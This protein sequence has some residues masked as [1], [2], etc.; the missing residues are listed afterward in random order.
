[1]VERM[2]K[3]AERGEADM[4]VLVQRARVDSGS[5]G[6]LYDIYYGRIFNYCRHRLYNS[7]VAEDI[8]SKVFLA[9]AS[10]IKAFK[11]RT[12]QEFGSWIYTI[13]SNKA[14]DYLRKT[15][16]RNRILL[17]AA[18]TLAKE[19][20]DDHQE[21]GLNWP[22]LYRGIARLKVKEQTIVTLRFFEGLS[23]EQ[24][25][26]ITGIKSS[27]VGVRIHRIL[28]KLRSHLQKLVNGGV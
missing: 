23:Y 17:E 9:V 11:G 5:F 14:N 12:E 21:Q 6:E 15:T 25:S 8:T 20:A 28:K 24:I 2:P 18:N 27:T 1:M 26:A 22:S 7:D 19:F 13:A 10:Q 3:T 4:D 16:R